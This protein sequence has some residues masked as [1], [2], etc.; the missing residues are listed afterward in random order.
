M[1]TWQKELQLLAEVCIE[2][3]AKDCGVCGWK[4]ERGIQR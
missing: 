3:L 2:I 1:I 4:N